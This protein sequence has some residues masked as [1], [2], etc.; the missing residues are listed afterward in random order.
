MYL[1]DVLFCWRCRGAADLR[2]EAEEA[3]S[4]LSMTGQLRTLANHELNKGIVELQNFPIRATSLIIIDIIIFVHNLVTEWMNIETTIETHCGEV[5]ASWGQ[6]TW[7]G[8][9]QRRRGEETSSADAATESEEVEVRWRQPSP[10]GQ[11]KSRHT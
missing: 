9:G 11:N 8:R 6:G 7:G 3:V 2:A 10:D 4:S 5:A 1:L